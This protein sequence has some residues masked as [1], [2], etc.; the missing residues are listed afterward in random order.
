MRTTTH[1]L[2]VVSCLLLQGWCT[3]AE[4]VA[5]TCEGIRDWYTDVEHEGYR[6]CCY[7]DEG[8]PR[9]VLLPVHDYARL[10]LPSTTLSRAQVEADPAWK[11]ALSLGHATVLWDREHNGTALLT[12]PDV[13]AV[14]AVLDG[15]ADVVD[16]Q[17]M[18]YLL[19]PRTP[20]VHFFLAPGT[21]VPFLDGYPRV[22]FPLP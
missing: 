10:T 11:L 3:R 20:T 21:P 12:V 6:D 19:I 15:L 8:S 13:T 16:E 17:G 5:T 4:T 9:T 7:L 2:F 22:V 14:Q 1:L 18:P